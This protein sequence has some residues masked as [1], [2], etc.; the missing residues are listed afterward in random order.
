MWNCLVR[1][2]HNDTADPGSK[3]G[4]KGS[5]QSEDDWDDEFQRPSSKKGGKRG[6]KKRRDAKADDDDAGGCILA[7]SMGLGKSFQ[8]IALL[9]LFFQQL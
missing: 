8:T 5:E 3:Q 7:H 2:H 9:W 4:G 6:N 1:E